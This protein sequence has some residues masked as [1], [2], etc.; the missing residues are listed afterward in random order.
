L[1]RG[2]NVLFFFAKLKRSTL[3]VSMYIELCAHVELT[4]K[5]RGSIVELRSTPQVVEVQMQTDSQRNAYS[6]SRP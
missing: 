4:G 2:L 1:K 6:N 3:V 5:E